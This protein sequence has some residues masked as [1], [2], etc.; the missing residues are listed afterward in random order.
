PTLRPETA[1]IFVSETRVEFRRGVSPKAIRANFPILTLEQVYGAIAFYLSKQSEIDEYLR[2]SEEAY[3]AARPITI[4]CAERSPNFGNG[5]C[6]LNRNAI[7]LVDESSF[8]WST[9]AWLP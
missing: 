9:A 7:P 5:L 3:E 8:K 6:E 1:V 2:K 4:N